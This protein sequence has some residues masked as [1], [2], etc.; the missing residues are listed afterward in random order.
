[1]GS[2]LR[3]ELHLNFSC[4]YTDYDEQLDEYEMIG[5]N[6]MED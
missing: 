5:N 3:E 2:E 6:L 4:L 1:M